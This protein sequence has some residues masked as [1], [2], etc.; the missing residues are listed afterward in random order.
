M[1]EMFDIA[2]IRI[3]VSKPKDINLFDLFD[4]HT[5]QGTK[6]PQLHIVIFYM[7][8]GLIQIIME[9]AVSNSFPIVL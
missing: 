9:G 7:L 1:N 8:I 3:A 5:M 4:P 6:H 2:Q